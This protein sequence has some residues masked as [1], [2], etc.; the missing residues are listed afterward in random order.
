MA[1]QPVAGKS[2][3]Q[4]EQSPPDGGPQGETGPYAIPKKTEA[5]PPPPTPVP[6]PVSAP[7][8]PESAPGY[9]LTV[10]VPVVTVEAIVLSRDGRFIPGPEAR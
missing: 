10:N 6:P 4:A 8:G 2:P 7:K 5:P 3:V 1:G 9:S